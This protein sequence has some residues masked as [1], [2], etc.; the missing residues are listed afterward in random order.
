MR[1]RT[2]ILQV[3]RLVF[4]IRAGKELWM[5]AGILFE[6]TAHLSDEWD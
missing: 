5:S 4:L 3:S 6:G 2:S 1:V